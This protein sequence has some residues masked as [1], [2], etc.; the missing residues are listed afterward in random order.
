MSK[1]NVNSLQD[2]EQLSD[3]LTELLK[4]GDK[5]LI[6]QAV[7][8]ELN[9]FLVQFSGQLT[10][11]GKTAVVRNEYNSEVHVFKLKVC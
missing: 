4:A 3:P 10:D 6:H 7:E 11:T 9:E 1:D 2:R 8:S 5:L